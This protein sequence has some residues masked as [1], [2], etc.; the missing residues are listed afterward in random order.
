[1]ILI[2]SVAVADQ[3]IAR[4]GPGHGRHL[5]SALFRLL[6]FLEVSNL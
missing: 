2:L 6:A 1:L 3:I 5:R 4:R